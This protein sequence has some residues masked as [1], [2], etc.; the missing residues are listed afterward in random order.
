MDKKQVNIDKINK[1]LSKDWRQVEKAFQKFSE[2]YGNNLTGVQLFNHNGVWSLGRP[3][4]N[5][6]LFR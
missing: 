4:I 3:S 5:G 2:K 1:E 6:D